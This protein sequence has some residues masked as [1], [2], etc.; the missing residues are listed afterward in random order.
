MTRPTPT[1]GNHTS[2]EKVCSNL[3]SIIA[4]AGFNLI[5]VTWRLWIGA[6]VF[7]QVPLVSWFIGWPNWCDW[8]VS[9]LMVVSLI[10]TFGTGERI[11]DNRPASLTFS[12]SFLLVVLLNQHRLQPWAYEFCVLLLVMA[13]LPPPK[14][15]PCLRLFVAS[16]YLHSGLSKLDVT[17]LTTHGE[18]FISVLTDAIGWDLSSAPVGVRRALVAMLPLGEILVA[19]GLLAPKTRRAA[20][21]ISVLMH[22]MLLW[23]LGP[24]GLGHQPGVLIWNVYF[25]VQNLILFHS[26]PN[27]PSEMLTGSSEVASSRRMQILGGY[28]LV[29]VVV[30]LPFLEPF[31]WYDHWPSWAVYASRPER[32]RVYV[33]ENRVQDLPVELQKF[34]T[35]DDPPADAVERFFAG[36]S[37]LKRLRIDQWSLEVLKAPIY[38]EDRFQVGVAL[39]LAEKYDLGDDLRVEI[40]GPANRFTGERSKTILNGEEEIR[41]A[42]DRFFFNAYPR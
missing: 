28:A 34:V 9:G 4:F 32:V 22:L 41:E 29:A 42:C 19:V 33:S 1:P 5:W 20:K 23:I 11:H 26:N 7:P 12:L 36:K 37:A 21:W 39:A 27:A 2:P 31:G 30:L 35:E 17:F 15:V 38:P 8:A 3:R 14:A 10:S 13:F 24:W 6:P 40:D 25:I 16:I 18:V